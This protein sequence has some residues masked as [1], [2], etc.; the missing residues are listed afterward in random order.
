MTTDKHLLC[1]ACY[2]REG[3]ITINGEWLCEECEER[4]LKHWPWY[5]VITGIMLIVLII[6]QVTKG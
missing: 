1:E 5:A 4:E 2:E 3:F 6:L